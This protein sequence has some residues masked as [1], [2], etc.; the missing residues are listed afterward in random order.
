MLT[1]ESLNFP[2]LKSAGITSLTFNGQNL[3][4]VK[5]EVFCIFLLNL[6]EKRFFLLEVLIDQLFEKIQ[7]AHHHKEL[8]EK[9]F[10]ENISD[11]F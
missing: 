3:C 10:R 5:N 9:R 7:L 1:V 8:E 11:A 4:Q 2:E 6:L